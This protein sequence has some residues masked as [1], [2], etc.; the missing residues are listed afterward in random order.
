MKIL[1][2]SCAFIDI[3]LNAESLTENAKAAYQNSDNDIYLSVATVWELGLKKSLGKLNFDIAR[4]IELLQQNGIKILDITLPVT[5]LVNELPYHHKDP[6]DRIIIASA[7]ING[8]SVMTSDTIFKA[9]GVNT[10][11]SRAV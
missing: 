7:K 9:Y 1:L 10:I 2:D 5:L 6:F 4:A 8:M 3:A 11:D